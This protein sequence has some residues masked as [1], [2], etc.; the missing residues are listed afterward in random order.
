MKTIG[1]FAAKTH[2]SR[3]LREVET[4]NEEITIRVHNRDVACLVPFGR[5]HKENILDPVGAFSDIRKKNRL[6][7]TRI[8]D[9]VN[10]GRKR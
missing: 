2:L 5:F 3:L 10:E 8:K 7:S 9:L 4:Q 1:A 6:K